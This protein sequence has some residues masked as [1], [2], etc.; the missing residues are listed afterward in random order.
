M[1]ISGN[2]KNA[3][4]WCMLA[5][6]I[7]YHI[8]S[9][10]KSKKSVKEEIDNKDS[11][12]DIS[13]LIRPPF[14]QTIRRML[15]KCRLAYMSTVDS[16]EKTSHLSLMRFTYLVDEEDGEVVICSTQ[17]NTK[18]FQMLIKQRGV[19]LLIHDFNDHD[20]SGHGLHS[21]TLNGHCHIVEEG[22]KAEK[23][24]AAHLKHNPDYPQFIVGEG[25]SI[26][27]II[28]TSARICNINDH[29]EKWTAGENT[30]KSQ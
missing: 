6:P 26:L 10:H 4:S 23:Y 20:D 3:T 7:L 11:L 30:N 28:V 29:V 14:P 24:R 22:E 18:K 25:V 21:I 2:I 8:F 13:G 16:I 9:V 27:C 12:N 15:T 19:A 17:R 5:L 1:E